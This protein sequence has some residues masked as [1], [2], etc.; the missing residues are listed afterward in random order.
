MK[1]QGKEALNLI[2]VV[3][4]LKL[5]GNRVT[6][7]TLYQATVRSKLDYGC[8]VYGTVSNTNLR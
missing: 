5:E 3:A 8:F 6:P 2:R 1:I 7:L 4:H